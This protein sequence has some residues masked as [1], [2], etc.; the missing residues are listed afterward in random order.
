LHGRALAA[1]GGKRLQQRY[2][3]IVVGRSLD[4]EALDAELVRRRDVDA[5]R[6]ID[7]RRTAGDN[8]RQQTRFVHGSVSRDYAPRFDERPYSSRSFGELASL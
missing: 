1:V 3:T 8:K 7:R 4:D 6:N 5:T 2:V